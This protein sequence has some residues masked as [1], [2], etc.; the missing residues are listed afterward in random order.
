MKHLSSSFQRCWVVGAALLVAF[1]CSRSPVRVDGVYTFEATGLS[2]RLELLPDGT[3]K[4]TIKDSG[5]TYN[6]T[7]TWHR[8]RGRGL[9]FK[10]LLVRFDTREQ[11]MISPKEYLTYD[12]F[13]EKASDR[14]TFDE[15]GKYSLRREVTNSQK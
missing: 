14:I 15:D 10:N 7:G 8:T 4:Q 1:G 5:Y 3:F 2:E 11:R 9:A 6:A 13:I 12:G